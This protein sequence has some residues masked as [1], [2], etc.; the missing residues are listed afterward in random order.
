MSA[1]SSLQLPILAGA[2]LRLRGLTLAAVFDATG[3]RAANLSAWLKG[4]P[5]VISAARVTALL[6]H[7]G[8]QGGQLRSDMVHTWSDQGEW[9][10]LRTVFNLLQEPVAPRCL[11]LDEHPGMSHTRFLQWG[12]AWVRLSLTPGPT[13][14]DD[15]AAMVSPDRMIVLPVALEGIPTQD[16]QAT[17]SALL[18][19]AEQGGQEIP[20][21]ELA[22]GFMQRLGAPPGQDFVLTNGD[23]L[24]WRLLEVSLRSAMRRGLSP[25]QLA[26]KIETMRLDEDDFPR[27]GKAKL[28]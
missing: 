28:G 8:V 1:L 13:A 24:G 15:L 2:L 7:L 18:S 6:Y 4:R 12:E 19:L 11:F 16:P 14:Q 25:T 27:P 3:I 10:H 20:T 26:L 21:G 22:H 17:A 9:A 23:S 5:Q